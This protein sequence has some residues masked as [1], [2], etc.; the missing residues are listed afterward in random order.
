MCDHQ[1]ILSWRTLLHRL[2]LGSSYSPV[3]SIQE[4][5]RDIYKLLVGCLTYMNENEINE[6]LLIKILNDM[7]F[8]L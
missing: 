1:W 5:V 8:F 7:G 3:N 4:C 6:Q 2:T